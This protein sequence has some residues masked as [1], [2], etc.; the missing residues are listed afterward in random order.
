MD[1]IATQTAVP[2]IGTRMSGRH[3]KL[4][5]VFNPTHLHLKT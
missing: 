1:G 4:Q 2:Q 5:F 3:H